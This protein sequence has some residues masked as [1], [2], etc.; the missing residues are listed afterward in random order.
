MTPADWAS[1]VNLGSAGAVI[2]VVIIFL[3]SIKERDA[4][5]RN[6]FTELN[7]S[8]RDEVLEL[9]QD[10]R[11]TIKALADHDLRAAGIAEIAAK[12]YDQTTRIVD[13]VERRKTPRT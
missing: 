7:R 10:L 9:T 5:W 11:T 4:E 8:N 3:R 2:A 1:I 13:I 12:V 6:F